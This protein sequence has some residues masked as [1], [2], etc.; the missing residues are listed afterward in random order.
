MKRISAFTLTAMVFFSG[1]GSV[2]FADPLP[3]ATKRLEAIF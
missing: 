1:F 2:S 3:L